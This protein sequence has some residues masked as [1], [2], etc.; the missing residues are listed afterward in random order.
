MTTRLVQVGEVIDLQVP[1]GTEAALVQNESGGKLEGSR[2]TAGKKAGFDRI[3]LRRS[4]T[5]VDTIDV[6]VEAP[7]P[8]VRVRMLTAVQPNV[9]E[10]AFWD[11]LHRRSDA[12]GFERYKHFIDLVLCRGGRRIIFHGVDA[13]YWLKR[14]TEYFLMAECGVAPEWS[15]AEPAP[16]PAPGAL[17]EAP[18]PAEKRRE[19]YVDELLGSDGFSYGGVES[20][21]FRRAVELAL[22]NLPLKG[23]FEEPR[24]CYG[25][26]RDRA[27]APCLF[28]LIW[29]YWHEEGGL[30]QSLAAISM[31]FQNRLIPG[32]RDAFRRFDLNPLRPITNLLWGYVQDE[33]HRLSVPRRAYEYDHNYGLTLL[34]KAVPPLESADGRS[35]FLEAFHNL[36]HVATVFYKQ[37]DN[38]Q[39]VADG[40]PVLNALKEV[41]LLLR[42]GM[43]NQFGDLTWT[44]RVEMLIQQWLLARPEMQ[45]FLG[46]RPL[47][48]YRETWMDRVDTVRRMMGWG[49]TSIVHFNDLARFG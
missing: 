10:Q 5:L 31:R 17:G 6:Q 7:V 11:T 13:Y 49:D 20:S 45:E 2:Y 19:Q 14:A 24:D 34:G 36:L 4:E 29:S 12:M 23:P 25:I 8:E 21:E 26:L 32:R 42:E 44:A 39:I 38:T 47:V 40:F 27:A 41:N 9:P 28:E 22:R 46:G 15:R 16:A 33:Q 30:V 3:E 37:A 43:A 1:R 18:E 48:Q 35:K